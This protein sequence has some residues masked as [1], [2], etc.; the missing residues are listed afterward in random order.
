MGPS[1]IVPSRDRR[2]HH[3]PGIM[4]RSVLVL[5][6]TPPFIRWSIRRSCPYRLADESSA[7]LLAR[8]RGLQ[9]LSIGLAEGRVV[10]GICLH[11]DS[12]SDQVQ[13]ARGFL[14]DEVTDMF[15]GV[16]Q[17]NETCGACPANVPF[18]G[19]CTEFDSMAESMAE[20]MA[21]SEE[22]VSWSWAGCAG[23]LPRIFD[24]EQE[25]QRWEQAIET[26]RSRGGQVF[27]ETRP[28]W[29]GFWAR[30]RWRGEDGTLNE[31]ANTIRAFE[32]HDWQDAA[33]RRD[34]IRFQTAVGRCLQ[35]GLE[36]E[37]ELVPAGHSDGLR[38]RLH[39]HCPRCRAP[40][41]AD[42]RYCRTCRRSGGPHPPLVRKV[43]GLRP[44]GKLI[45]IIGLDRTN[46]VL[47]AGRSKNE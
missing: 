44:Y 7:A 10:E 15:G 17:L 6:P 1:N 42:Q 11:A 3:L 4:K 31:L 30:D 29:Y 18:A 47:G 34:W 8:F 39:E 45:Q 19:Q 35:H 23:W 27:L 37:T 40:M 20:S 16:S 28:P 38:W 25:R 14:V 32:P 5:G 46:Q 36:L 43:L 2:L 22:E 24:G 12:R 9:E 21:D 13:N 33:A 26:H 41:D